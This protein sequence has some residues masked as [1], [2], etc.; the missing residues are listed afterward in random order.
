MNIMKTLNLATVNRQIPIGNRRVCFGERG[1]VHSGIMSGDYLLK[2]NSYSASTVWDQEKGIFLNNSKYLDLK[3]LQ[4]YEVSLSEAVSYCRTTG[5]SLPTREELQLL[6]QYRGALNNSLSAIGRDEVLLPENVEQ[7]FWCKEDIAKG[8]TGYRRI[9]FILKAEYIKPD[10]LHINCHRDNS[11]C[12]VDGIEVAHENYGD[13]Y[14][15]LQRIDGWF[16][17]LESRCRCFM[18]TPSD[19]TCNGKY[20]LEGDQLVVE[21]P[22]GE[23]FY[24]DKTRYVKTV[25]DYFKKDQYGLYRKVGSAEGAMIA[26]FRD[27]DD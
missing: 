16:Y 11:P 26:P 15:L 1:T 18:Y 4:P 17:V 24:D 6:Q 10:E 22:T 25:K 27:I 20:Y 13:P 7:H 21:N 8:I 5:L 9:I 3:N 14:W 23:V 2:D 12:S 19:A